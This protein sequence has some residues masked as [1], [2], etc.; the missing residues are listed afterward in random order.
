MP[1]A[2]VITFAATPWEVPGRAWVVRV[3]RT[4]GATPG[5]LEIILLRRQHDCNRYDV[6]RHWKEAI[7]AADYDALAKAITPLASPPTG[8]FSQHEGMK[9]PSDIVLDGTGLELRL[10]RDQWEIRRISNHYA[11]TG[12]EISAI[13]RRLVMA[14]VPA[15]E[16]PAEDWRPRRE[17]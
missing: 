11:Q 15:S 16:L 7:S 2:S 9:G 12:G 8:V 13:F 10:R 6:E 5:R 3:S 17:R 1:A 14:H 4:G